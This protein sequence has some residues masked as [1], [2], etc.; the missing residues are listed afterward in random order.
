MFDRSDLNSSKFHAGMHQFVREHPPTLT[1][2]HCD[3]FPPVVYTHGHLAVDIRENVFLESSEEEVPVV[4][5][6]CKT[7]GLHRRPAVCTECGDLGCLH[8]FAVTCGIRCLQRLL[9]PADHVWTRRARL[10]LSV[11]AMWWCTSCLLGGGQQ[12]HPLFSLSIIPMIS[13]SK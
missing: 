11:C 2:H 7:C 3:V 8:C 1:F 9:R 12:L 4:T 13:L 6:H 10:E 5:L